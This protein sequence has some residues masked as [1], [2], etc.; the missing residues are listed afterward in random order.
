MFIEVKRVIFLVYETVGI[1]KLFRLI[2]FVSQIIFQCSA[3]IRST[4]GYIM[5]KIDQ[6]LSYTYPVCLDEVNVSH[7]KAFPQSRYH[8]RKNIHKTHRSL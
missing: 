5:Y 1:L 8:K 4:V 6:I 3:I 7:S 2:F